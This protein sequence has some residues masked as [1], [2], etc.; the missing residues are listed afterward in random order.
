MHA[1]AQEEQ[2]GSACTPSGKIVVTGGPEQM[3]RRVMICNGSTWRTFMEQNTDGKSL[4][5]VDND[6]GS[7]TAAKEGR[8]RFND[9]TNL[10]SYCRSGSWTNFTTLPTCAVGQGYVMTGSG[11]GCCPEGG[12]TWTSGSNIPG[13]ND[14]FPGALTYGNGL[15]VLVGESFVDSNHFRTSPDGIT[16]TPRTA[17]DPGWGW[18]TVTYGNGTFVA[19]GGSWSVTDLTSS[20]DGITWTP[21]TSPANNYWAGIAHGNGLFVA[22]GYSG[23]TEVITSPDGITWTERTGI[24]E[25]W[26][27]V[28]YG[29][30]LFVAV[31]RTGTNRVMTSPDGITWT[32]R[33]AAE[34]NEWTSVTYGGGQFVAVAQTGTNRVMTSPDGITWTART[35]AAEQWQDVTY[36]AGKFITVAWAAGQEIATSE[37]GITWTLRNTPGYEDFFQVASN[38]STLVSIGL[39]GATMRSPIAICP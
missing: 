30:G 38:S 16:W 8:L 18:R 14:L 3:P 20:T 26:I 11:W 7:C 15:F 5:Q 22:V 23:G 9:S 29:N 12:T 28:T 1:Y 34:N 24:A 32:A 19:I 17:P 31:G 21:R 2:P 39:Y 33:T 10:W 35:I 27:D 6:T 13:S 4:F 37:D 36:A 25:E